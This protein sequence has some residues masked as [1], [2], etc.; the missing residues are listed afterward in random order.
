M[1]DW[2]F[3]QISANCNSSAHICDVTDITFLLLASQNTSHT[4]EVCYGMQR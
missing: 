1:S 2:V 4:T 3:F